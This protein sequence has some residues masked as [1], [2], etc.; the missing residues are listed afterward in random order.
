[1]KNVTVPFALLG[2]LFKYMLRCQAQSVVTVLQAAQ[3]ASELAATQS[4][5]HL[6]VHE[7]SASELKGGSCTETRLSW[8]R[9]SSRTCARASPLHG[10]AIREVMCH[11]Q[12][13]LV[14]WL[15][16]CQKNGH[17]D[18]FIWTRDKKG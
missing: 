1:M 7:D 9:D 16:M 2:K 6:G 18:C 3:S 11:P 10:Y 4:W 12:L 17:T 15:I 8:I 14:I 13:I 5:S